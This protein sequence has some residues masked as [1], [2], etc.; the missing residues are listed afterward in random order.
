MNL[1]L[2]IIKHKSSNKT[3]LFINNIEV[4]SFIADAGVITYCN[5]MWH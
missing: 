3:V 4:V 2:V 5:R 1:R